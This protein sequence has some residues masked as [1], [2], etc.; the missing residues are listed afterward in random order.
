MALDGEKLLEVVEEIKT[1][2]RVFIAEVS[3][4]VR[5][6][7]GISVVPHKAEEAD[8]LVANEGAIRVTPEDARAMLS[9]SGMLIHKEN[10]ERVLD[11]IG[12]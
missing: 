11:T 9:V 6:G 1:G 7:N 2:Q 3:F 5:E 8:Y 4:D 12:S 10:L